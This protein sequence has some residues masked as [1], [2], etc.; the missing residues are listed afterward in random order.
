MGDWMAYT[1][2]VPV[3]VSYTISYRVAAAIGGSISLEQNEGTTFL[4]TIAVPSTGGWQNWTTISHTVTLQAGRQDIAIG[5]PQGGYNINWWSFA[6]NDTNVRVGISKTAVQ[7]QVGETVTTADLSAYPNPVQNTLHISI[8]STAKTVRVDIFS[9]S[10]QKIMHEVL[11]NPK[12]SR[13][14]LN[15]AS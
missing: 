6:K 3:A 13:L 1:I 2:E 8:P 14:E 15:V 9:E 7:E 10:G 5:V 4:G 12:N 11:T